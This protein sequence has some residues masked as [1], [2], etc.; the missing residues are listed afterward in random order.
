MFERILVATDGSGL[1]EKAIELAAQL[2][3][4]DGA[5]L[6]VV[7]VQLE[8]PVPESLRRMVEIEQ[9]VEPVSGQPL[10]VMELPGSAPV[11]LTQASADAASGWKIANAVGWEILTRAEKTAKT[12]GVKNVQ[13]H[14]EDGDPAKVI[15]A[16]AAKQDTDL[17]VLG[18]RG[19]GQLERLVIGSVSQAVVRDAKCTCIT[20]K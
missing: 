11:S 7:H 8:G 17:V 14:L 13:T 1:S 20:V 16:T 15:L 5:G 18:S 4:R 6:D 12:L 19:L 3:A 9:L 2:A 10:A